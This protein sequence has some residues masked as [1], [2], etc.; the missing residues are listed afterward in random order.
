MEDNTRLLRRPATQP[1]RG[2]ASP[3][4]GE[5]AAAAAAPRPRRRPVSRHPGVY[6]RPRRDGKV[7]PPYEICY[8]DSTGKR[9]WTV[10]H[11]SIADAEAKKAE[12][13]LRRRRG[14]RIAP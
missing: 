8:L 12:L 13:T 1:S 2:A 11:G 7:G 6:Y 14:E 3:I 5:G 9:R 10:I 4:R